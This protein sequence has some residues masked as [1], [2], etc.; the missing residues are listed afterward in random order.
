MIKPQV[1]AKILSL[2]C[3]GFTL[4]ELL[5]VVAIL[6]IIAGI[7][8]VNLT[9]SRTR[10][11]LLS[12]TRD[13]ENWLTD[14]RRYV[15]T[16]KLTCR[17]TI[18]RSN[19][20]L[21]STIDNDPEKPC[22]ADSSSNPQAVVFD[23]AE[24]FGNGNEKLTMSTWSMNQDQTMVED[25]AENSRIIRLQHQGYSQNHFSDSGG[26]L[27][28]EHYD[29]GIVTIKLSH[30]DLQQQRC[31]RYIFPTG[32]TRDGVSDGSSLSSPCRYNNAE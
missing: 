23:L 15:M 22:R 10:R 9:E 8:S 21:V 6:G 5:I 4:I 14:Q 29:N 26:N 3:G 24:N 20:Q 19:K 25:P 28:D 18:D 2:K 32:L 31:I 7:A 13:L 12:S 17:I 11:R 16:H 27:A 1:K 30:Q